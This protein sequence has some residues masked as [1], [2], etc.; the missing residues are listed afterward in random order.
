MDY[1]VGGGFNDTIYG[2]DDDG[3]PDGVNMVFGDHARIEFYDDFS[4][5]HRLLTAVPTDCDCSGGSDTISLGSNDDIVS[6]LGRELF[7]CWE[8]CR[9]SHFFV[10]SLGT[11]RHLV[12]LDLTRSLAT[13]D[14][15]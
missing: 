1:L 12:A 11:I 14:K 8:S 13:V 4:E 10:P 5:S 15:T 3:R 2:D 9:F 7:S 6:F